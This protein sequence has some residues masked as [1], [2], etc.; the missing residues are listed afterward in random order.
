MNTLEITI[1]R[2]VKEKSI[3]WSIRNRYYFFAAIIVCFLF[4]LIELKYPYYFLQDDNR[5]FFLPVYVHT[6][7]SL[8]NGEFAL[9]NFHQ[10]LGYP[11]F[12]GALSGALYPFTY[13]SVFLSEFLFGHYF[14][15]IDIYVLIHLIIGCIGFMFFLRELNLKNYA[16]FFGAVTWP[17]S[18]FIIH[19]SN[20]W[21][22]VS[23]VA[24]I[25]PWI[26]CY[27][28]RL[29]R[30]YRCKEFVMLLI[31]KTLLFYTGFHQY[32]IYIMIFDFLMLLILTLKNTIIKHGELVKA[33]KLY[34]LNTFSVFFLIL[35]MLLPVWHSMTLSADRSSKLGFGQF[36][37]SYY[38]IKQWIKGIFYPFGIN[39]GNSNVVI[40]NMDILS[41]IGYLTVIFIIICYIWYFKPAENKELKTFRF[42]FLI[43]GLVSFLWATNLFFNFIIYQIPILNRLRWPFKLEL[44]VNFHLIVFASIG[45]HILLTYISKKIKVIRIIFS[46]IILLQL[47]NFTCLYLL[48]PQRS[49][50]IHLDKIPLEEPLKDEL[51]EGRIISLG[52]N[53]WDPHNKNIES[54][55]NTAPTLGFNYATL[56]QLYHFA[57]YE[58]LISKE[59]SNASLKLNYKAIYT[60]TDIPLDYFRKWGVRW[61]VVPSTY[62]LGKYSS[63]LKEY[64]RDGKRVIYFDSQANPLFFCDNINQG[65][66]ISYSINTNSIEVKVNNRSENNILNVNFLYNPFFKAYIDG[67]KTDLVKNRDNQM[68]ASIPKGL[69]TVLIKYSDPYFTFGLWVSLL[70]ALMLVVYLYNYKVRNGRRLINIFGE[71]E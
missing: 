37:Y 69:H 51:S 60:K 29:F 59:N 53:I 10:F 9:Y 1:F 42:T 52:F 12:S 4:L 6:Y 14:A 24:A 17:L 50:A 11:I 25:Y 28:I 20:A 70:Y 32:F 68:A 47:L 31:A 33:V 46:F 54:K 64:K 2:K 27:S 26:V 49:F 58:P 30:N 7:R 62:N 34:A 56:W 18:S 45:L 22:T 13:I 35:P 8:I 43:L 16:A 63:D 15:T 3:N 36:A 67:K 23:S 5:D 65:D 44:L 38:D 61:Y 71:S 41:H 57:G 55:S 48:T 40:W 66:I 19:A 39:L 21:V